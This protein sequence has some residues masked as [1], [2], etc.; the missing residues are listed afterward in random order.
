MG[1]RAKSASL[2][3]SPRG[4]WAQVEDIVNAVLFFASDQ[5]SWINGQT[6]SVDG[7]K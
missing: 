7:G 6:L 1:R 4:G 3:A 2:R 5:A